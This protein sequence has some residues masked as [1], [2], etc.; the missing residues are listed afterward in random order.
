MTIRIGAGGWAYFNVPGDR[1]NWYSKTFDIVEVNST[2]YDLPDVRQVKSWRNR[3]P[4]NFMFTVRCNKK[5]THKIGFKPSAE[6]YKTYEKMKDICKVLKANILHLQ[7]SEKSKINITDTQDFFSSI[8]TDN[9]SL[10]WEIRGEKRMADN[11][12][13]KLFNIMQENNITHCV[14][15]SKDEPA[16]QN[17][18]LAYTRLF[19]RGN[20]NLWQFTDEEIKS[21]NEKLVKQKSKITIAIAHTKKMYLDAARLKKHAED[22]ILLNTTK[23]VG[24]EA[25]TEVLK[26]DAHFPCTKNELILNQGWKVVDIKPNKRERLSDIF[27]KIPNRKYEN[28]RTLRDHLMKLKI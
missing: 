13:H 23:T 10:V 9:V 2:F 8:N 28:I 19:G 27:K 22:G 25:I 7:T 16:Y 5:L 11:F 18:E 24:V 17:D 12:K 26:E 14:D 3:V 21:V 1:L 4:D 15:L 6:A 20:H